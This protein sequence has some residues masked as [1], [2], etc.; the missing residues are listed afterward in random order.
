MSPGTA[1]TTGSVPPPDLSRLRIDR[2]TSD[3]SRTGGSRAP[4]ILLL[5]L[6]L[7]GLGWAYFTG[8]IQVTPGH[9]SSDE[10]E[11]AVVLRPGGVVSKPGE[12][13]GNGYVIARRRAALSTVLSG[14]LVEVNVE[15]G[16]HV[17][18]GQVVARIQHDDIDAAQ[19]S[20]QRDIEVARARRA[21]A[22]KSLDASR[23]DADRLKGDNKVLLEL[24]RQAQAESERSAADLARN[25]DLW[26]K[27]L[28][29]QGKWDSLT[30]AAS[31]ASA[32]LAA[33]KSKVAAG[34][35]AET[36]W[37]GEI[38]RREAVLATADA[39]ISRA[40]EAE[41]QAAILVEKTFV[42]APFAGIVVH[43]D[44]EVGEVVAATG[45]GGNSRGSVATIIDPTT[46]EVQVE[47]AETRLGSISEGDATR[48][49]LDAATD[50]SYAGKIRQVWPTADRQKATVE[51]RIEF[52]EKPALLKPEM[53]ARVT[54][55]S[56]DAQPAAGLP[57]KARV[58]RRAVTTRDGRTVVFTV[59]GGVA[60][61]VV[62]KLGP[63][64]SGL[65]PVESGL[66]GG[67]TVVLDPAP[68]LVD[69]AR[70][71]VKEAK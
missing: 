4:W 15:E 51:M 5:L 9:A 21:E 29:D 18:A 22:Q 50:K 28:I 64:V 52:L 13:T 58:S 60:K 3:R 66:M 54:F 57:E 41:R 69:G 56:K 61:Q 47:L 67:E 62:V 12:V 32:A 68:D 30:A 37:A 23:L 10:V 7:G 16:H 17:D 11:T 63:D 2:G 70:V 25:E 40:T 55:L 26:K 31:A 8:R 44:A 38:E 48:I 43:K 14:R 35:A 42:R 39:E 46:L 33:S 27:R 24:V 71:R 34:R 1:P 6:V 36:A 65:S 20:A 59:V 49:T 45:A 19:T 53:G